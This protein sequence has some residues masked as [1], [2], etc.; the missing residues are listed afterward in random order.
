M[1]TCRG[2]KIKEYISQNCPNAKIVGYR[3]PDSGLAYY[4]D[5]E[6]CELDGDWFPLGCYRDKDGRLVYGGSGKLIHTYMVGETGAGKTTRFA[7][8]CIR[9]LSMTKG[10]PSFVVT[11]IHGEIT[12]NLYSHLRAMG[13][14]IK[15][16]NCDDPEH[17]DTYNPLANMAKDCLEAHSITPEVLNNIRRIAEIIQPVESRADPIWDMGARSYTNGSILDKF[18]DLVNGDIPLSCMTLYNIIQNHYWLR[19]RVQDG[20][21]QGIMS[22]DHYEKK[23]EGCLSV[24]KMISVTDNAE[25]TRA[26]Y[27]GVV[28]NHYDDFAQHTLYRLFSS[29]TIDIRG[30]IEKPTVIVIPTGNTK[31]GDSLI[32]LMMNDI[33]TTVV[34][35]GKAS[36]GKMLPRR[37]HCFL[38]EFANCNVADGPEFIKMLTTSRKFGMYWHMILQC[39]AQIDRKYDADIARIIRANSTE[40]FMGSQDYET[41]VRFAKSCGRKTVETLGSVFAQ[42]APELV[43]VDLLTPEMLDL[44]E[45]GAVYVKTTRRPLLK[46]YFEAFYKCP[47]FT[48]TDLESVY[49]HNDFDYTKTCFY[50]TDV[51]PAVTAEQFEVLEYAA[52]DRYT[53]DEILE[54]F[55]DR[56]AKDCLAYLGAVGLLKLSEA[57]T[58]ELNIPRERM[59]LLRYKLE[60][61]CMGE[62]RMPSFDDDPLGL[63]APCLHSTLSG[64]FANDTIMAGLVKHI[65]IKRLNIDP[66]KLVK[67][68]SIPNSVAQ[69]MIDACDPGFLLEF[70]ID[71]DLPESLAAMKNEILETFIRNNDFRTKAEW[72]RGFRAEYKKIRLSGFFTSEILFAYLTVQRAIECELTLRNIM[73]IK[74]ITGTAGAFGDDDD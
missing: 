24:Q 40:L 52:D 18:E 49:P 34:R 69:L 44:T 16:L 1:N 3:D 13:Y 11:D 48:P 45:E 4:N 26:S 27:Y 39:D 72:T 67:F 70:S 14:E 53:V 59:E 28:E 55:A 12:E 7:M 62:P 43:T 50:P 41:E 64:V 54:H 20:Y 57:K 33:Y 37:I 21:S 2:Q 56:N 31:V 25:R 71:P 10:K 38:D 5:T 32:S 23:S 42:Q 17:S 68:T 29:S 73:E 15:I 35:M 36:P 6:L 8:Q 30:F 63:N 65:R 74:A 66:G 58:V 46:S 51:P 9:A 47:E 22:I 60:N 19:R 61:N